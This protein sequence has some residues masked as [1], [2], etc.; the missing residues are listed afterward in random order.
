MTRTL[1]CFNIK[2]PSMFLSTQRWRSL[3]GWT[4][5]HRKINM[6]YSLTLSSSRYFWSINNLFIYKMSVV[7]FLLLFKASVLLQITAFKNV[8][9]STHNKLFVSLRFPRL[10]LSLPSYWT[11][12]AM[13]AAY[14]V[15]WCTCRALSSSLHGVDSSRRRRTA[16]RG[17]MFPP[18]AS[19]RRSIQSEGCCKAAHLQW[20][21]KIHQ[22]AT[23]ANTRSRSS[24]WNNATNSGALRFYL[25]FYELR[26]ANTLELLQ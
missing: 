17:K 9:G 5:G 6:D 1:L 21:C 18:D 7:H 24:K 15:S 22:S 14:S 16:T 20:E 3:A 12:A 25:A 8:P 19:T 10:A 11:C 26:L 13:C 23:L 4:G 2:V